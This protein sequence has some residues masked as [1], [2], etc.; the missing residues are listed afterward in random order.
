M[1]THTNKKN[2]FQKID[3]RLREWSL[4]ITGRLKVVTHYAYL[5]SVYHVW[6]YNKIF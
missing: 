2:H 6:Q 3:L 5:E 4:K 1:K